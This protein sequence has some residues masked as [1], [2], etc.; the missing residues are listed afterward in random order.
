MPFRP[1]GGRR[2]VIEYLLNRSIDCD[3]CMD[4]GRV[5]ETEDYTPSSGG[6]I[7]SGRETLPEPVT[8]VYLI[9]PPKMVAESLCA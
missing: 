4:V 9:S 2:D 3:S 7:V 6:S 8:L 5:V 1:V